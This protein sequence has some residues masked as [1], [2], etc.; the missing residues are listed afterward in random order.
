[1]FTLV[2]S[3]K[4]VMNKSDYELFILG[5]QELLIKYENSFN[6][7]EFRTVISAMGFPEN[8]DTLIV[9]QHQN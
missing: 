9:E 3:L 1:M 4:L 8:W 7:I 5:L 2:A 6:S